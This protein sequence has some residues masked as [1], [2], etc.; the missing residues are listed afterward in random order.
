MGIETSSTA[1]N[2]NFSKKTDLFEKGRF[3]KRGF[4]IKN[5]RSY[6]FLNFY[7]NIM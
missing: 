1:I 3:F 6:I 2:K 7:Q 4:L 5:C